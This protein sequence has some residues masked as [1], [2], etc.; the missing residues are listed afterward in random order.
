M[1][2]I[3]ELLLTELNA[4]QQSSIEAERDL[5]DVGLTDIQNGSNKA[6]L[7]KRQKEKKKQLD[8]LAQSDDPIDRQIMQKR[9]EIAVLLQKKQMQI[10]QNLNKTR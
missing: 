6:L 4:M 9:R 10:K 2:F 7:L 8:N 5:T 1:N 3:K